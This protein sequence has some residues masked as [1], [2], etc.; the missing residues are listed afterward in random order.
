MMIELDLGADKLIS[1]LNDDGMP[2]TAGNIFR[3][4]KGRV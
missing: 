4:I 3:Q 2:I 1:V